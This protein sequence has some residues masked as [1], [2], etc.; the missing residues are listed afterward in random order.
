MKPFFTR[1]FM[2]TALVMSVMSVQAQ[3]LPNSNFDDWSGTA[4]DGYPQPKSW[5]ASHV[6]Q[7][8]MKFNF[9]HKE[10]GRSGSCIMVQDQSVGAMG[11]TEESPGYIALGQPWQYLP[12]ITAINQATAGTYGG[13]NF[14]YRPDSMIV[15]VK[16]TGTKWSQEDFHLLF[17]SWKGTAKGKKYKG[18]NGSC[19]SYEATNEES[20]VRQALDGNECGT[21]T[22]AT[23]IAEGWLR[24]RKEYTNWTRLSVPIFYMNN[25]VPEMCNVIL[26]A[27]NY[28]NFR[29]N[30]GLYEGN[31]LYADDIELIYS[32]K[33][34]ELYIGGKIWNGFDPNSTEEQV[35]SVGQTTV[36]P[37]VYAVRGVGTLTN[38][39]GTSV[40]FPGRRLSGNEISIQYG[41]V[42]GNPTVITVKS[43][44]GKSTTTYKIKMVKEPSH[45]ATLNSIL[46]NGEKVKGFTPQVGTYNVALP[47]GTTDK[48]VVT[49]VKAEEEQTVTVNQA[50]STTGTATLNVTAADGSTKKTYTIKFSVAQ[51][52]D[53]TLAGIKVNGEQI[54]DFIPT[55][56]TYRV[57]LP[58]GTTTMPKVEAVSAYPAGAQTITYTAPDKIDGGQYQISVTTPG[59]QTA[60]VYK[61]NFKITASSNCKLKDLRLGN[62][63]TNFNPDVKTYY[64]TFPMGTTEM[65]EVEYVKGDQYQTVDVKK[66]GIDGTTT[67]TVTAGNGTSTTTYKIICNTEKSEISY[68]NMIYLDGEPMPGF[69]KEKYKYSIDLPTGSSVVPAITW[70]M[71]DPLQK[72][73]LTEGGLNATTYILVTADNGSTSLYEIYF[74]GT[75]ASVS[76]L[77]MITLDGK[78]LEGFEPDK[79]EYTIVLPQGTTQLPVIGY[80]QHDDLQQVYVRDGGVNGDT[81][82]IVRSQAGTQTTYVLHFSVYTSSNTTLQ[83]VSFNGIPYDEFDPE[84]RDYEYVL[85]EGVSQ[86][87][88]VSF[89]KGDETQKVMAKLDGTVYTIRVIA[90]NGEQGVYTFNFIIQKSENAYLNMIYLDGEPLSGFAKDRLDYEYIIT[91]TS[92]PIITVDKDPSQHVL[93]T[94]PATI[95]L[96]RIV[97]TPESGAPNTYTINF[98]S[99]SMPQLQNILVNDEPL[100]GFVPGNYEYEVKYVGILPEITPVQMDAT[101][102]VTVASGA[103]YVHI[104]VEAAEKSAMYNLTLVPDYS[105]ETALRWIALNGVNFEAYKADVYEYTLPLSNYDGVLPDVTFGTMNTKQHVTAGLTGQ[106][107]YSL[108]VTAENGVSRTYVFHFTTGASSDTEPAKITLDGVAVTF[109]S[110]HTCAQDIELGK[111]LP[112][113]GYET[114]EG[115]TIVSAQTSE[116]QQQL[117][118]VAEDGTTATYT[119]NY[120]VQTGVDNAKLNDIRIQLDGVWSSLKDFTE[121]T[122]VYTVNLP[123]DTTEA[124]CVWPVAGKPGQIITV[125]YGSANGDTKIHVKSAKGDEQDYILTFVT[126]KS[127]NNKLKSLSINLQDYDVDETEITI[128]REYGATEPYEVEYEKAEAKQLIEFIS[129]P[130]T[131]TTKIIVTAENGDK[132]TYSIRYKVAEPQGENKLLRISYSFE[133]AQGESVEGSIVPVKG[134]NTIDLPFGSKSFSVDSYEKNYP[135]Q[136]VVFYNGGI[137]RGATLI[138]SANREGVEDVTYTLIPRMPE[139]STTGKLKELKFKGTLVP[140]FRPDVYNYMIDVTA[141]PTAA[142]FTYV[143]YNG[144]TVKVSNIDAKMK[145]IKFKV[146]NGETYSVCWYYTK[147][148]KLFDFSNDWVSVSQGVGYKP[149]S[150]WTVPADCDDGYTWSISL[151]GLNLTYTTGKEVTPGGTNGVVLSTLRGAP[152]N[153]SVP[154]MMTLGAMSVSLTSNGNSTSSVSKGA[155]YGAEFKNT[156]E[157]FTFL[158][159]PLSTSNISNWKLWLTMSDGSKY[160]ESNHTGDFSALNTWQTVSV[161]ISYDGVGTVSKFNVM[162]SSCD[163]ENAGNFG[164]STVYESS[165]MYDQ[166]HFTYNSELTA[167][168]VNGKTTTKS[169]NTFTYKLQPDEIIVGMPA[170]KFTGKVHDQTQTIEWLNNGEWINGELTAKVTN[171][172]EN[173]KDYTEYY[174][175]LKRDAVTSTACTVSFGDY[176]TTVS[177]DTV[178]VNMPYGTKT[179]PNITVA[180]ES[181]HQRF[182]IVKNGKNVKVKVTAE[183]GAVAETLY[184]FREVKSSVTNVAIG[185]KGIDNEEVT[186]S[187]AFDVNTTD[188]T[189]KAFCMPIVTVVK[190]NA[191]PAYELEDVDLGQT[192]DLKYTAQGATVLVTAA[193][194]TTK[195][196]TIAYSQKIKETHGA[197]EILTRDNVKVSEF[198]Q[199]KYDY[200]E[201]ESENIGFA[202]KEGQETDVIVETITDDFV[203]V[204]VKG[205]ADAEAK[206]YKITYP[207]EQSANAN[208]ADV[209][210]NGSSYDKFNTL[211][212]DIPAYESDEPMDVKFI[213][214]EQVQTME[215]AISNGASNVASRKT[216]T[217]TSVTVFTVTVKAENGETKTYTFTIRPQSS[218]INTLKGIY[219]GGELIEDFYPEKSSYTYVIPAATPKLVE[220]DMPNLTYALGQESQKVTV[221]PAKRVGE[222]T[223]ISVTPENDDFTHVRDYKITFTAEPSHNA[224]LKGILVNGKMVD[225]FKPSRTY[226]SCDV[227][228]DESEQVE[229]DYVMGDP[230]QNV[231]ITDVPKGKALYVTAQDGSTRIYELDIYRIAKSNNANLA[232]I[233]LDNMSMEVYASQHNISS[234]KFEEKTY[235]YTVPLLRTDT[236]P[237]IAARV[238][239]DEQTVTVSSAVTADGTVKTLHVVAEDGESTNDYELLFAIE[240]S[241]N[242]TLSMIFIGADSLETFVPEVLV[243]DVNLPIGQVNVP[244]VDGIASEEKVQT[245]EKTISDNGMRT[246]LVVTAENGDKQTYSV[247]FHH[248][249][250]SV[251]TLKGIYEGA[252]L[253]DGFRPDSFYYAFTLPMGVRTAP[254]P[255]FEPGDN[256]QLPQ[257]VDTVTTQYRTTYLCKVTAHD[258]LH[259]ETYTLVYDIQPSDVDTLRSITVDVGLGKRPLDDFRADELN[260]IYV[261]PKTATQRPV[262]EVQLGDPY[263]DTI[264]T[265]VEDMYR[266]TVTAESGRARTYTIYFEPEKS[267]DPTLITIYCGDK[268]ELKGFDPE[269]FDYTVDLPYGTTEI[270]LVTYLAREG[271]KTVM[272]MENDTI[273]IDVTA[274]NGIATARYTLAFVASKSQ[275]ARLAAIM[276]DGVPYEHFVADTLEYTIMLP[277]GTTTLPKVTVQTADSTATYNLVESNEGMNVS[278]SVTSADEEHFLD[279]EVHFLVEKCPYNWLEDIRIWGKSI[280][281]FDK[282]SLVYIIEYPVGT[283][284]TAFFPV[285]AITWTLADPSEQVEVSGENGSIQILVTAAN[286]SMR[287]YDIRQVIVL[288]NNSLLSDLAVNGVTIH[289]FADSILDYEYQLLEGETLPLVEA[290]PQDSLANVSVTPGNIGEPTFIYCTAQDGSETVYTIIFR[291]SHIN[292][293]QEPKNADVLFKQVGDDQFAVFTIRNNTWFAL[294]D[295][296]GHMYMNLMLPVS[297]P[298]NVTTATDMNGDEILT[299]ANG[300]GAYFTIPAHGQMFFYLF[301]SDDRRIRTGKFM[302]K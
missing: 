45:N 18:K 71:G 44:D 148:D 1:F 116:T 189:V 12:S 128:D 38:T 107:D 66:G 231:E 296:Q 256:F 90:E 281:G 288:P 95:G 49:Y 162:L 6:E 92:C 160:K 25:E 97:V 117:I 279:Y 19:T 111:E 166:I 212:S 109:D 258:E 165:V 36:V 204:A 35:Y 233:L 237:D 54:A 241:K 180:P 108:V 103:D 242:T 126:P 261:V 115:Q 139:F 82:I 76:T 274:E 59:N 110:K 295:H 9:A 229:I 141:Q 234:L 276:L 175:V 86:V 80:T 81:K 77:E 243:Y 300:D 240:K 120:N 301:Y 155:S 267:D 15:W 178:F 161:P 156:P 187:P 98:M 32:S 4:F 27:S 174:V 221:E 283:D 53:N 75:L 21:D 26:S 158:A 89:V 152:M 239:D 3:Q 265:F 264:S 151:I 269:K 201:K 197:L 131:G 14:T 285:D 51:L 91:S 210:I 124:P 60:K 278:I 249:Y 287:Q 200:I 56:T 39:K 2:L 209:L 216:A 47:Y 94:A 227:S 183:N 63:I 149:S 298:N 193:D 143:T 37:E 52:A 84:V 16:R 299:D 248:T 259:T 13:I 64:V 232:D 293:S 195:T 23:Q 257:Q 173:S 219:I 252:D 134:D 245:V 202:R 236:L 182:E 284:P 167:V 24:D 250:S 133:N 194:G 157:A 203:A 142:D 102:K 129:A 225:N 7:V 184:V 192:V 62:Y 247:I 273:T 130:I 93:I 17:Y 277:Y 147:Y 244:S 217:R 61:L 58:V 215:I 33:I 223:V 119:I 41:Q 112:E 228:G 246:D 177:N 263:Q 291:V 270:P 292:T 179:L 22:K 199:D 170:L 122:Y 255:L 206:T 57:E 40:S 188:Y 65:P 185:V 196:Y 104:Y 74:S 302:V 31:S 100:Q 169:G 272:A 138:V 218:D 106:Y 186:L 50:T 10:T 29:A 226:Y 271:Q 146:A 191:D 207:T 172:G 67:V 153:G 69:Q 163:Q 46:V 220:P 8:G 251:A 87:P 211:I 297:N 222:T 254:F 34:Q 73:S 280:E 181:V 282:D 123:R 289:Q 266:I 214:A 5:N 262:V 28:P 224:E 145:Q 150:A 70:E 190:A 85:P 135:E 99:N 144:E 79:T 48:P 286:G 96:A 132:R 68:L 168:T 268:K 253:I 72:V 176:S 208:L 290:V 20:D 140:N 159:K 78:N 43:G 275:D 136:A 205:A 171:Y 101:Q 125:T 235:R 105:D 137:R 121:D 164:G 230:F 260:Y 30:S 154:G 294:Y 83:S 88:S 238:Q 55:L 11:I 213:L 118:V 113:L 114:K 42:D 198:A 127:A